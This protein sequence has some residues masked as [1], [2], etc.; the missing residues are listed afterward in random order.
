MLPLIEK[1]V[2]L[3]HIK[4]LNLNE[5]STP[6]LLR[7]RLCADSQAVHAKRGGAQGE[8][9]AGTLKVMDAAGICI[10]LGIRKDG[11]TVF[12]DIGVSTG[13]LTGKIL[14]AC[15]CQ[16]LNNSLIPLNLPYQAQCVLPQCMLVRWE[17]LVSSTM[18]LHLGVPSCKQQR[19]CNQ[20]EQQQWL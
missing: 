1:C 4:C 7:C 13:E 14:P 2:P 17:P 19:P 16:K 18:A 15:S 8:G 5:C 12:I 11:R 6:Y 3:H 10:L 20:K 9:I